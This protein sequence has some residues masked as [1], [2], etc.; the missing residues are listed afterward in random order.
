[1]NV[2]FV[3]TL[4]EKGME[5]AEAQGLLEFFKL[6]GKIST[7]NMMCFDF[8]G[9]IKKYRSPEEISEDFYPIRHAWYQKRK[10]SVLSSVLS[11][12]LSSR[13]LGLYGW[14]TATGV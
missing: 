3:V 8:D 2:H 7:S 5:K 6:T 14:P 1:M 4:G 11:V 12:E 9:K 10:V 13:F